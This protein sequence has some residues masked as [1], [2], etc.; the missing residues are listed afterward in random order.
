VQ[1]ERLRFVGDESTLDVD[2]WMAVDDVCERESDKES[3]GHSA[4]ANDVLRQVQ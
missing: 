4:D 1:I 3:F 2:G